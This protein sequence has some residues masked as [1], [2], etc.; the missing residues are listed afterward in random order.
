M[1]IPVICA[2]H[3][4]PRQIHDPANQCQGCSKRDS[5]LQHPPHHRIHP[6]LRLI[7]HTRHLNSPPFC[8]ALISLR[9]GARYIVPSWHS[10]YPLRAC[11]MA[12]FLSVT[13]HGT[14][15]TLPKSSPSTH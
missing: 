2:R 8:A 10:P 5:H 12:S 15:S 7:I 11:V 3:T 6:P 14:R 1:K 9:V 13:D 4:V